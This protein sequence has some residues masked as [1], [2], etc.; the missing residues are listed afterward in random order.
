MILFWVAVFSHD[1]LRILEPSE[2]L[3][4]PEISLSERGEISG[5]AFRKLLAR[6]KSRGDLMLLKKTGAPR[7]GSL[8]TREVEGYIHSAK[9]PLWNTTSF[10]G[11]VIN[12][13]VE[14]V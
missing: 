6:R 9:S 1:L 5:M 3:L 2:S 12:P 14:G 10:S 13:S 8:S 11:R 4:W 7:P